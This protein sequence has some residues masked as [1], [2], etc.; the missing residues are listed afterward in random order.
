MRKYYIATLEK[1]PRLSNFY[2][3]SEE[4]KNGELTFIR[5]YLALLGYVAYKY[6]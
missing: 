5:P 4:Q 3:P 6:S 2:V 1:A